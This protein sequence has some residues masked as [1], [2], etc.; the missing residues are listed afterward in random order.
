MGLLPYL[1]VFLLIF[2]YNVKKRKQKEEDKILDVFNNA[3]KAIDGKNMYDL[4]NITEIHLLNTCQKTRLLLLV[5][6]TW[7]NAEIVKFLLDNGA[8]YET[9]SV[10]Y[11]TVLL[12]SCGLNAVEHVDTHCFRIPPLV[13]A[14]RNRNKE[15]VNWLINYGANIYNKNYYKFD[16]DESCIPRCPLATAIFYCEPTICKMLI[17]KACCNVNKYDN[18]LMIDAGKVIEKHKTPTAQP[19]RGRSKSPARRK[20]PF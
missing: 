7:H 8:A 13:V 9:I 2:A 19:M 12:K 14:C 16:L 17:D 11:T 15:A 6:R 4:M 20:P 18:A 5:I 10:D 3:V 1:L